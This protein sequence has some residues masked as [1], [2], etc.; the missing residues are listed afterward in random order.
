MGLLNN[1][2]FILLVCELYYKKGMSQKEI[3]AKLGI[4]RPQIS[5]I[6]ATANEKNLVTVR[7]N[8][9][10]E[11]EN[12][13][14]D[15]LRERYGLDD[16]LVCGINSASEDE[17]L[18]EFASSCSEYL[19]ILIKDGDQVGVMASKTIKAIAESFPSGRYRG[20]RYVPLSGG[21]SNSGY[22]WYSN[23]IVQTF[24]AKTN[25]KCYLFNAPQ[26]VSTPEAKEVLIN[27]PDI[28]QV[29]DQFKICD[30]TLIGIGNARGISTGSINIGLGSQDMKDLAEMNAVA[31]VCSDFLDEK[32]NVLETN[33]SKRSLGA[34]LMDIRNSKRVGIAYGKDK[35]EAI[36]AVLEGK[37]IDVLMTSLDTAKKII[38]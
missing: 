19:S 22:S 25:G 11:E 33:F 29:A 5:R 37:H 27:E 6:I 35:C 28:R 13:Y 26:M 23:S 30:V 17:G 3:S 4:S 21:F 18:S 9:P 12:E 1:T 31:N 8:Y 36:K 32:G 14:Q 16:V 7:F 34:S 10:N 15:K 24:A 38:D 2:K 20:L